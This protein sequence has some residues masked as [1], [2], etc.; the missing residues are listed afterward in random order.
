MPARTDLAPAKLTHIGPIATRLR[1]MDRIECEA[2]G[3]TPKEA[4][5]TGLRMS[6]HPITVL[7]DGYPEAMLGVM[8]VSMISGRAIPWMLGTD[9]LFTQARAFATFGPLIVEEWLKIFRHLENLVAADNAPAIRLLSHLGFHV[10]GTMQIFGGVGFVPFHVDRP[11]F[12]PGGR[13]HRQRLSLR[14]A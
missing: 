1:E 5:R 11:R 14:S 9:K 13:A 10:G 7:I 12:K 8:P 4:L 3:R 6:M 2:M